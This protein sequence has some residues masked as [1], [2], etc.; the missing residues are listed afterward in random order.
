MEPT[1]EDNKDG[2]SDSKIGL[3]KRP[4]NAR[5][6]SISDT[7]NNFTSQHFSRRRITTDVA[8]SESADEK[9]PRSRLPI[10]ATVARSSSFFNN[11]ATFTSKPATVLE[12][13]RPGQSATIKRTRTLSERLS[14]THFFSQAQPSRDKAPTPYP[15]QKKKQSVQIPQHGLMQPIR[16]GVPRSTT[17]GH[18]GQQA[19]S[20]YT[21]SFMRPTSSSAR[22]NSQSNGPGVP[23][24]NFAMPLTSNPTQHGVRTSSLK[25]TDSKSGKLPIPTESSFL[26]AP[27]NESDEEGSVEYGTDEEVEIGVA[28]AVTITP[29]RS[30]SSHNPF[31]KNNFAYGLPDKHDKSK[32]DS[33]KPFDHLISRPVQFEVKPPRRNDNFSKPLP[34]LTPD[35]NREKAKEVLGYDEDV[36]HL[37]GR[38]SIEYYR[39]R[40]D[41]K[42]IEQTLSDS[43]LDDDYKP[44]GVEFTTASDDDDL[45]E[46]DTVIYTGEGDLIKGAFAS[47][48]G[49]SVGQSSNERDDE[50]TGP[51]TVDAGF[52]DPRRVSIISLSICIDASRFNKKEL[53]PFSSRNPVQQRS[54]L[55]EIPRSIPLNPPPS[56]SA[57]SPP[58]PTASAPRHSPNA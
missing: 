16:P 14:S 57:A 43:L 7:L 21:P 53:L 5:R 58:S 17:T 54:K 25:R 44:E 23:S 40:S 30:V 29:V 45:T 46:E 1:K 33:S 35:R 37:E 11:L 56:G 42:P 55:T 38:D 51:T 2:D 10:P 49:E 12:K 19:T 22:R 39:R 3:F 32:R 28:R 48:A 47:V 31:S 8:K 50:I 36:A 52:E 18:L 13:N 20:G 41:A 26:L 34:A 24:R 27:A 6:K 15:G 4:N 9:I